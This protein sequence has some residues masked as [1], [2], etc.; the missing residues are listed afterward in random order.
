MG[1][2]PRSPAR[3]V[4][5]VVLSPERAWA[6]V[7]GAGGGRAAGRCAFKVGAGSGLSLP[8]AQVDAVSGGSRGGAEF[9]LLSRGRWGTCPNPTGP[10]AWPT[11]LPAASCRGA[12]SRG[13]C[14][15]SCSAGLA[16]NRPRQREREGCESPPPAEGRASRGL[17][18]AC[19]QPGPGGG[20]RTPGSPPWC[21]RRLRCPGPGCPVSSLSFPLGGAAGPA[22]PVC[23]G[24]GWIRGH[25]AEQPC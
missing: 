23:R 12:R 5:R 15:C 2:S 10:Q 3:L 18:P 14:S 4:G 6:C 9:P 16:G 24:W 25:P 1:S 22:Q 11:L 20:P 7:G 19:P 17:W 21:A 13:R 8:S